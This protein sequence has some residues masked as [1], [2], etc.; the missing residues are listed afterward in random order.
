M[1]YE[2]CF[3]VLFCIFV[4]LRRVCTVCLPLLMGVT[5]GL[6]GLMLGLVVWLLW[7]LWVWL[8]SWDSLPVRWR[9]GDWF[10]G[11]RSGGGTGKGMSGML[12][13]RSLSLPPSLSRSPPLSLLLSFRGFISLAKALAPDHWLLL[14]THNI[15][16]V[17]LYIKHQYMLYSSW[18][19]SGNYTT[20]QLQ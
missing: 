13:A 18:F 4:E 9:W 6:W 7:L 3:F 2:E 15:T 12:F 11:G 8:P 10:S 20:K 17:I 19:S 5:T 16:C 1:F 14:T